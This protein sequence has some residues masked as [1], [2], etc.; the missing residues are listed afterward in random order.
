MSQGY[1]RTAPQRPQVRRTERSGQFTEEM[2]ELMYACGDCVSPNQG[3]MNLVENC[4]IE[5]LYSLLQRATN[6]SAWRGGAGNKV[7]IADLLHYL[8]ED[9]EL[10][11]HRVKYLLEENAK[12]K[13]TE[14]VDA[15]GSP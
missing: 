9:D 7:D 3:T 2:R 10:I 14:K 1:S 8:E 12:M 15:P 6:R 13:K 4:M 11:F 5:Y